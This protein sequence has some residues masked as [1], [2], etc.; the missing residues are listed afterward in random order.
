MTSAR[1]DKTADAE[2]LFFEAEQYEEKGD[3]RAA[4][5][6][7]LAAGQLGHAMSQVNLGNFYASGRGVR[8]NLEK[9]AHWYKKGYQNGYS[10]G[11]LNLAIDR[12]DAGNIRSAVVWFKKAIAMHSGDACIQLAKIYGSRKG[13]QKAAANLLRRALRM[14]KDNISEAAKEE[15]E[16]LLTAMAKR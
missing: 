4:F 5:D 13:G 1:R 6:R 10:D 15:A 7:L 16:I 8:R 3:Y 11:A 12:R 9:A 14:S 2:I